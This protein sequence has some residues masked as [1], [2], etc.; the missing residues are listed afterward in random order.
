MTEVI[1]KLRKVRDQ[2]LLEKGADQVRLFALL[3]RADL[4]D[5]WDLLFCADWI[6]KTSSEKDLVY[7]IE[8]IKTEFSTNLDFLARIVVATPREVFIKQLAKA[9]ILEGGNEP[10]EI[11]KLAVSADFTVRQLVLLKINF[12][13]INVDEVGTDE[14]P[15]AF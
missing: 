11:T 12:G 7:I 2:I 10:R 9:I 13:G 4:E 15:L 8:K 1:E 3:A 6:E 5:K 14:G